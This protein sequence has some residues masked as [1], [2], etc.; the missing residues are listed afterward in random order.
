MKLGLE[1]MGFTSKLVYQNPDLDTQHL[2]TVEELQPVK[3][4]I[5]LIIRYSV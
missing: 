3:V 4:D 2:V 1:R 5:C